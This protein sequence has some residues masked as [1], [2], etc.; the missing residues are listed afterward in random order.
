LSDTQILA[1]LTALYNRGE[2]ECDDERLRI[3]PM[4]ATNEIR[5]RGRTSRE[6][7]VRFDESRFIDLLKESRIPVSDLL[8]RKLLCII[9]YDPRAYRWVTLEDIGSTGR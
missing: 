4:P 1:A 8:V 6:H 7:S 3:I 2:L 9:Y 5:I